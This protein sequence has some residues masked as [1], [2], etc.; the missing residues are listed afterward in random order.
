[1]NPY[2]IVDRLLGRLAPGSYLSLTHC[3]SDFAPD[4]RK[5]QRARPSVLQGDAVVA[6]FV[7]QYVSRTSGSDVRKKSSSSPFLPLVTPMS[8]AA[9]GRCSR[10]GRRREPV[11]DAERRNRLTGKQ[12]VR[13]LVERVVLRR[14][15]TRPWSVRTV[16]RGH[17]PRGRPVSRAFG[18][19]GH[20]G[21]LSS[22]G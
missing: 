7:R 16:R 4:V 3:T 15:A 22:G 17:C 5:A 18:L 9:S 12:R 19:V 8:Q 10:P 21:V 20:C 11:P 2:G 13:Q 1:M 6:S 14:R